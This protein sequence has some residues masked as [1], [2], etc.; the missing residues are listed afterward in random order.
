[1]KIQSTR[2]AILALGANLTAALLALPSPARAEPLPSPD[3]VHPQAVACTDD[4]SEGVV[5]DAKGNLFFSHVKWLSELTPD[6]KLTTWAETGGPNGHKILPNGHH[7]VC[8]GHRILELD[9][10]GK[11]LKEAAS[12]WNGQPFRIPNDLTLDGKGGFYFTDPG[13]SSAKN[14]DGSM[15][16][17]DADGKIDRLATGLAFPNGI[18]LSKNRKKLYMDESA[19]NRV[20]VWDMD[21]KGGLKGEYRVFAELPGNPKPGGDAQPDGMALDAEGRL[22]V[23]HYGTGT[24]KVLSPKGKLLATYDA[25]NALTSNLAFAGPNRDQLFVTGGNPGCLYRLDVKVK[26]LPLLPQAKTPPS[27][28]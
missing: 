18:V 17:V 14:P 13:N 4:Y 23:A 7:L 16:H 24:V 19:R 8:D 28:E 10:S 27:K 12:R 20:V 25:G 1:L 2:A 3:S 9:A 11:T 6:G 26:G 15:Y 21:A 22:W 5:E